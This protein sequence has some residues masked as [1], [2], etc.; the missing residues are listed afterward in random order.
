VSFDTS[1]NTMTLAIAKLPPPDPDAA[2]CSNPVTLSGPKGETPVKLERSGVSYSTS[3][4]PTSFHFDALGEPIVSAGTGA[5][6]AS[7]TFKI[8]GTSNTITIEGATGYVH[9]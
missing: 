3:Q 5:P 9:E 6:Q 1:A 7:Q 8:Q 2:S 4:P